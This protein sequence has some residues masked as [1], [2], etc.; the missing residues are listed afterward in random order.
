MQ[1]Q[2][3]LGK[4]VLRLAAGGLMLFHGIHK[5]TGG[6]DGLVGMT[7][8]VGLP[9]FLAYGV[10]VGE[11]VVPVMLIIGL[12]T[13]LSAGILGLN[14]IAAIY[15]AHSDQLM[16]I[17]DNT[18]AWAIEPAM[19]FLLASVAILLLGPGKIA[20]DSLLLS[21]GNGSP[22]TASRTETTTDSEPLI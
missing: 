22:A 6:I 1:V 18:G 10:Y 5:I 4:L 19:W 2:N 15:I 3:D 21:D 16:Q 11:V 8:S 7:E 17:N 9:S 12:L 14:M 13:R 20:V